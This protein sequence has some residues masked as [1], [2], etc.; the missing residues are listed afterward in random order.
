MTRCIKPF[1]GGSVAKRAGAR[2]M[3][4]VEVELCRKR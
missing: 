4:D 1:A 2:Y 3:I